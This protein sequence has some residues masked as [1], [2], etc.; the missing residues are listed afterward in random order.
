MTGIFRSRI[1]PGHGTPD[2]RGLLRPAA[3]VQRASMRSPQPGVMPARSRVP[4]R[5][6]YRPPST[7]CR[8]AAITASADASQ[9]AG[10]MILTARS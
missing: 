1:R 9:W 6:V 10:T 2:H 4:P 8:R 7:C 3:A 5:G